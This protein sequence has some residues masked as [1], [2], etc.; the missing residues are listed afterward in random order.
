MRLP[1]RSTACRRGL[2]RGGEVPGLANPKGWLSSHR[3]TLDHDKT[4]NA[5]VSPPC[6]TKHPK[7]RLTSR[8]SCVTERKFGI[9][10]RMPSV[11]WS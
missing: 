7:E 5:G 2:L 6:V 4:M 8:Q 11:K 9:F 3:G 1:V 10:H